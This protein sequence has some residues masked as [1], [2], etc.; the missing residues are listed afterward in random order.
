MKIK[1]I[2]IQKFRGFKN[3]EFNL[4]TQITAIVGQNGTQKTTLLGILSQPFTLK[5][6]P[7]SS[8]RPL[9]GGNYISGFAEKFKF[10]PI[11]DK[12][13]E[14]EWSLFIEGLEEPLTFI[15]ILR[16]KKSGSIRF[17]KKGDKTKG[18]GYIALP[19][20]FLSLKRLYPI[21]EDNS[22]DESLK[23]TLKEKEI[24][25]YKELH[26]EILLSSDKL[27]DPKYLESK[28]KTTLGVNTDHY[29]WRQ[30]SAGQDNV[31]KIILSLL[32]FSRL[33]EN[34][35]NEYKGG[36]LVIDELDATMYPGSQ[37]K[38]VEVLNRYASRLSLQVIFTTHSLPLIEYLCNKQSECKE[39]VATQEQVKVVFLKKKDNDIEIE[40]DASYSSIKDHL[41]VVLGIQ[42]KTK[43]DVFTE[44]DETIIFAKRLLGQKANNLN[45]IKINFSCT[46]LI[47][48][49]KKKIQSFSFPNSIIFL[50]GDVRT[51][52]A[53]FAKI[54][55]CK[56]IILLPGDD[57][58][59]RLFASM[60]SDISDRDPYW[61]NMP[62]S[63]YNKQYC[64]KDSKPNKISQDR[65]IAKKW[66]REHRRNIGESW[67]TQTIAKWKELHLTEVSQFL[68]DFD[69]TFAEFKKKL[70]F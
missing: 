12:V 16:D 47:E 43:I 69:E 24:K 40:N 8:E 68:T 45:F 41:E 57:S 61:I 25:L 30:N 31:S 62:C 56:N 59:E 17:W 39:K 7:M 5:D 52:A 14:H 2:C 37:Y 1:K 63:N 11:F 48:L 15:S 10:S 23:V 58:P 4:G 29:D 32:S 13:K 42:K 53:T 60:L 50:D 64:F 6:H 33:K 44:D 19:V 67:C 51:D 35:P 55:Q 18:S 34:F 26:N 22:L 49:A 28:D 66:F 36:I 9:C 3:V 65:D 38:L 70:K 54:S 20:I 46:L 27:N 21:G